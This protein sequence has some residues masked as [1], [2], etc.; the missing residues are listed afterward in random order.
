MAKNNHSFLSLLPPDPVWYQDAIIYELHVR[1]F[2]DSDADGYG[3]FRGMTEKLDYLQDL[4]ITAIW[5]LPFYPSPLKDDGYDIANYTDVHPLYGKLRDLRLFLKEAAARDIRVIS[6][7]VINHTSD[8][9]PWFQRARR[10]PMGSI[11][12]GYYVWSDTPDRYRDARVIF[13]D[14][15]VSNWTWDNV[16]K[17]YYWHR[18]FSHQPDLNFANPRVSRAVFRFI[19]FWMDMGISG[20]RLDA[21]PYLFEEEGTI[22]ENLPQTHAF[23]KELRR[24]VDENFSDR[25]LLAEA[26][27]WPEDAAQY[28]TGEGCHM[29][30]HFPLMPR[31]FMAVQLEDRFPIIDILEQT[32]PIG[33]R[34]QWALF[35]RN[36][37]ELT[38]E[39]VTDEERDYM[40][41]AYARD[42][43]ARINLGIRRRLAPLLGNNRRKIELMNGLLM[44]LPG[45]P[46]IYYGDEIGMGDNIYLGDRNSV[47][48]PMQW[49]ADRN[50][51]FSRANPQQLYL[52]VIT[53]PEYRYEAI[54]VETQ[55]MNPHSLLWWMK[56]LIAL[57]KQH[58]AF[59]RGT[60]EILKPDN[61]KVLVFVRHF[62]METIL[63]M[64]NLSRYA[65]YLEL[66]LSG[67]KGMVPLE[68][69]GHTYFPRIGE[70][71]YFLTIGPHSFY[72]FKLEPAETRIELET[73]AREI[74]EITV[75][76]NWETL[77]RPE[78]RDALEEEVL[79][80]IEGARWYGS[81]DR[82]VRGAVIHDYV[83]L[84]H[85]SKLFVLAMVELDFTEGEPEVYL[86]PIGMATGA[87]AEQILRDARQTVIASIRI[88][89]PRAAPANPAILYDAAGDSA[90]GSAILASIARHRRLKG[91]Q[92]G[93]V[94]R[95]A[96]RLGGILAAPEA[97]FAPTL[98]KGNPA[99]TTLAYGDQL[100]L[101]MFRRMETGINPDL[102]IGRFLAGKFANTPEVMGSIEYV[103]PRAEPVSVAILRRA[104]PYE[105]TAWHY[106]LDVI[107]N[108]I[109]RV[110][111]DRVMRE[112]EPPRIGLPL[113]DAMG[114]ELPPQANELLGHH[115]DMIRL[116]ARRSA[117]MHLALASDPSD[118]AFADEPFSPHYQRAFYQSMRNMVG[119]TSHLLQRRLRTLPEDSRAAAESVLGLQGRI[120]DVYRAIIGLRVAARRI[121]CH[122]DFVLQQILFTGRD[123][124]VADFEGDVA[125]SLTE[126]RI[127][128][129]PLRDVGAMLHSIHAAV[130]TSFVEHGRGGIIA[131]DQAAA[132][133][134]WCR[135]WREWVSVIYLRTY[136][137]TA[138]D[139][140]FMPNAPDELAVLLNAHMLNKAVHQLSWELANRPE[141]AIVPLRVILS[142]FESDLSRK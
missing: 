126:R 127:K 100:A 21:I 14:F 18:F 12:R 94:C 3:D 113:V 23:L 35:L 50:A 106:A 29:A 16:A 133:E 140:N 83:P 5:L 102:E 58:K 84:R 30:F 142:L 111:T 87:A 130:F 19:D 90:F 97:G 132:V 74:R 136:L 121:R 55:L 82:T 76:G 65:Q 37:D 4:G 98:G 15:E 92:G 9:H 73:A 32:P 125:R 33:P 27:Q 69:F 85:E 40:Y 115:T 86:I 79:P 88:V 63:V 13:K 110:M 17:A 68:L 96:R 44:S 61:R 67:F 118:P 104:V 81:K 38:L 45:T 43:Q 72:W 107:G 135:A 47:R 75:A 80:Y 119:P 49:S 91:L 64:V 93:V 46:V 109:E 48:T 108:Y 78:Q 56:R 95:P 54:N 66:D 99:L 26:N 117:E 31:I 116:L 2:R 7:L 60:M 41:R 1:A 57:R 39:M 134:R 103:T 101:K 139:A 128:R 112:S 11:E 141:W 114:R 71:P 59:S 137:D 123:F 89:S 51:G 52:P 138:G 22:C 8:Q 131:P 6:E 10:T 124:M 62:E 105:A 28:L 120:L 70:L 20:M 34:C 53:D 122:G 25:M 36:H 24:H 42:K 129:S 77:L